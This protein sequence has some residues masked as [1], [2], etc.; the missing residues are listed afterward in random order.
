MDLLTLFLMGVV[1]FVFWYTV[2]FVSTVRE[3]K[4]NIQMIKSEL[5]NEKYLRKLQERDYSQQTE[6][7]DLE[8]TKWL[9]QISDENSNTYR[10]DQRQTD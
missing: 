6:S 1:S 2:D 5:D 9:N 3:N 4:R 7:E 8:I 10:R